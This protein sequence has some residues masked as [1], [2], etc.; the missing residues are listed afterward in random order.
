MPKPKPIS[1]ILGNGRGSFRKA[2]LSVLLHNHVQNN[3]LE[4]AEEELGEKCVYC[5]ISGNDVAL[6]SD[7]LWPEST[8]GI[9]VIGNVVPS[10]PTCNSK[11][12]NTDWK[13]FIK[14]S[15]NVHLKRSKDDIEKQIRIISN[16]MEKYNMIEKPDINKVL[17]NNEIILRKDLDILLDALSQGFRAKIGYPQDKEIKFNKPSTMLDELIKVAK[18]YMI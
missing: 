7:F 17:N 16:Y 14:T 13:V 11:R 10:C 8:G 5:G 1:Q 6:Q 18:K 12:G 2:F 4:K 9:Y 15:N 3:A